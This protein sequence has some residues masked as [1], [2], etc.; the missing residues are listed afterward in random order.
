[1]VGEPCATCDPDTVVRRV[2]RRRATPDIRV[3]MKHP[4]AS[5]VVRLCRFAAGDGTLID[6]IKK[7]FRTLRQ[8]A[9]FGRPI[10]HLSVDVDR[11]FAVPGWIE[12]IVPKSLEVG[13]LAAWPAAGNEKISAKLE[14]KRRELRIRLMPD[15][16]QA[17]VGGQFW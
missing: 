12:L 11:P 7:R 5:G 6:Q 13:R 8:I 16:L 2:N 4:P 9:D 3:V 14:I 15:S 1:M 17:L 10:V